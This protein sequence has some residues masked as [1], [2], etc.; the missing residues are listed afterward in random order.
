MF[1]TETS[2]R[3]KRENDDLQ[4]ELDALR[5]EQERGR[6]ARHREEATRRADS[7]EAYREGQC[8][9]DSWPEAFAKGIPRIAQEAKAEKEDETA[10]WFTGVPNHH[11]RHWNRDANLAKNFYAEVMAE[12]EIEIA[13]IRKEALVKVA[14]R[15]EGAVGECATAQALR[16]DNQE[17]LVYW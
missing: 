3:L 10:P 5:D 4:D 1:E 13:R 8:H 9:A 7:L 17:F 14:E 15:L 11:F 6:A 2:R 12:T 16:D